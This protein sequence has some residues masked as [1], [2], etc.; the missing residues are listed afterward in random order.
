VYYCRKSVKVCIF[1]A[2]TPYFQ[3]NE[4]MLLKLREQII[5]M[6]NIFPYSCKHEIMYIR[7]PVLVLERGMY[8]EVMAVNCAN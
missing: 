6:T 7:L 4:N 1:E 3:K 8:F 5:T 2:I